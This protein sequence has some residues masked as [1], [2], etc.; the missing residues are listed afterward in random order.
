[1]RSPPDNVLSGEQPVS[2]SEAADVV[3]GLE[4]EDNG[5]RVFLREVKDANL[6][7]FRV[8]VGEELAVRKRPISTELMQNLG[9]GSGRHGDLEEVVQKR[10]LGDVLVIGCWD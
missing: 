10:N 1:M 7:G 9:E 2:P 8:H 3:Q 4:E 5:L 6:L